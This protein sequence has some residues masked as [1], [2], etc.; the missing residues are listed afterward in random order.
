MSTVL[1][2]AAQLLAR[3]D[4]PNPDTDAAALLAHA[5]GLDASGVARRRLLGDT[6]P[7]EVTATFAQL[8]DRRR[9]RTPLQHII[10]V[11]AFRHLE[12]QVGPG[13]FV[14][15]PET[16]LLVTEVLEELERQQNTHVPFI[17]DLCSGSGAITLSL[18]TEHRR[19]RAIGVE[20][21]TQA[22]NWSLMN[23]AAVDL[24]ESSVDLVSGD[25]TTFAE[26]SPQLWASA[27]VVVTNPPYVPDTAVPRD[28]EVREHDPEAALYGGATGLEIPG[29]IIIQAEKL[30]RPGGF[31]IMEHSEE[32]GPAARELI[33]S[34]ASLRQ[35]ATYPDYTGRD[36]YTVAHRVTGV[37][38]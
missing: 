9:Q 19:L 33:M 36:R 4:V 23:L 1:R 6:V 12:L 20:R 10:G 37:D 38:R 32:Q 8:I 29:L 28:A 30:L 34:T 24:G 16:E 25:A 15:R 21:D 14:P 22:L 11:A 13:V 3:A 35:A 2:G 31:F 27:D 26:D 18:A 5:W 7:A 17:I